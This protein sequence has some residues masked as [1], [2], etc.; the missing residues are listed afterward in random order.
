MQKLDFIKNLTTIIDKLR[1]EEITEIFR[2]GFEI[3]SD[4]NFNYAP[5]T[6]I[7]FNSKSNYD[8][9]LREKDLKKIIS[10]FDL[11]EIYE[12]DNLAFISRSFTST[13]I[14]NILKKKE[15]AKFYGV[16]Q[17]LTQL[18]Q[19]AKK[20]L[21]S[22]VFLQKHE[23]QLSKGILIF[24][25]TIQEEGLDAGIYAEIFANL[26]ELVST[27]EKVNGNEN[28]NVEIILL[29]SGS[30]TNVAIKTAAETAKSL[31]LIFKEM[32]DFVTSFRF[33][34]QKQ[35][36]QALL[37]GLTMM[38]EISEKVKSGVLTED[39]GKEY[40]HYIKSRTDKL[41]G[42]KVIP[43]VIISENTVIENTKILEEMKEMKL[44]TTNRN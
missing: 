11:D 42:F 31:F 26:K 14:S 7:L 1:S 5:L 27:I 3:P 40:S 30:D 29:D 25:I 6:P 9:L 41:I 23:T 19:L 39:E 12:E 15:I 2:S 13:T 8:T 16:H 17:A 38:S 32:W 22:D 35:K 34:K 36:N 10:D 18:L 20:Q 24:Q 4:S 44:L 33:Y 43:K 28:E 21:I 37:D